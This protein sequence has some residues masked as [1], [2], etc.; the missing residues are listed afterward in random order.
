MWNDTD[1]EVAALV[2]GI[3]TGGTITGAGRYLRSK[4]P[5]I[6][7]FA[8]E[9]AESPLL[10]EGKAGPHKIQ[11][12]GANF[13]SGILDTEIYDE[14]IDR[15]FCGLLRLGPCSGRTKEGLLV[16]LSTPRVMP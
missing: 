8:V 3:G 16:G 4:N 9:P 6:K 13:I 1:G 2:S 11:G 5:D 12:L 14:V 15:S 7:I 10:S